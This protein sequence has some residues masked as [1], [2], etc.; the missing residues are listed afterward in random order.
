[1]QHK[2]LR[3]VLLAM[4]IALCS[5]KTMRS[6]KSNIKEYATATTPAEQFEKAVDKNDLRRAEKL[7]LENQEHFLE[8]PDTLAKLEKI[9]SVIKKRF[10]P[11]IASAT[12]NISSI[13][14]PA[15]LGQWTLIRLKLNNAQEIID[16]IESNEML[17]ALDQIPDGLEKLKR[18]HA[19]KSKLI[20]DDA[21]ARFKKYPVLTA[22]NFF[23]LYPVALDEEEFLTSQAAFLETKIASS[24]GNGVPH[25]VRTYGHIL[26]PE[27]LKTMEGR[28]F[29]NLLRR[30]SGSKKPSLRTII[31]AMHEARKLG[32]PITRIPDCKIAFV[33]VTSKSMLRDH[34]IE[35]GLGFDVDLP[36]E[37][38]QVEA[39]GMFNSKT[40]KDADVV[41]LINE[42]ISKLDRRSSALKYQ[43]SK[44]I[45]GYREV[46]NNA[47]DK[48]QMTVE[49][50]KIKRRE[51][52]DRI[53]TNMMFGLIG[54]AMSIPY[55]NAAERAEEHYNSALANATQVPRMI[56]KPI[57][58]DYSYKI[59]TINDA[60]IASVQY[61]IIDRRAKTYF[62]NVFDIVQQQRFR[63]AYGVND[64]DPKALEIMTSFKSDS[65][66][67]NWE[68]QPVNIRLSELLDHYLKNESKDKKY[69]N[70]A[71]IQKRIM[72]NRNKAIKEFHASK[73]D[74]DTGNDPRFDSVVQVFNHNTGTGSGFYVTDNIIL[75]N[76]HVVDRS[77][78][79]E[80]RLHNGMESFG[81]VIAVD[82]FRDLALV[83][84]GIRGKPVRFYNKRTIPTGVT[85][86]VIGH[87][88]NYKFSITRGIFSAYR[89]LPSHHLPSKDMTIRYIQTDAAINP[90]NSGGPLFY[91]DR[92]VGV[93]SWKRTDPAT[94]NLN[95]AVH[96]SEVID[97]LKQYGI[98][99][100]I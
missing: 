31:K 58:K 56:D 9:A 10:K 41:I 24:T 45:T 77:D 64:N 30:K 71:Q 1:M 28:F 67:R 39:K 99:Y 78:F 82:L 97:F 83:K 38:K 32:F 73:Y 69:R 16:E 90:G 6:I 53:N 70:M 14:W 20:A 100:R 85:L 11:R 18:Q 68:K 5:C 72:N 19:A 84:I 74:S 87:P 62:E 81:K 34:A 25:L 40:A 43:K 49:K 22:D 88:K 37:A 89:E 2:I 57:Y 44:I 7:W 15:R 12:T 95:F 3:I 55:M 96:Y 80:V 26:P 76:H 54:T 29:R 93:N 75:T 23:F 98:A 33:R 21:P 59:L 60:K 94:F 27:T 42:T 36:V 61:F 52:N 13:K 79:V 48:A 63:V 46:Y 65:D 50:H 17:L 86:D 47:Y 66:V 92:L 8:N 4:L 91:K 51:L 35:F